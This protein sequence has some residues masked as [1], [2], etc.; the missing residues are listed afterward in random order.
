MLM[1]IQMMLTVFIISITF[2]AETEFQRGIILFG[3]AADRT[4]MFGDPGGGMCLLFEIM[5][6]FHLLRRH[7]DMVSAGQEE[8]NKIEEG[9][10]DNKPGYHS[11]GEAF[12]HQHGSVNDPKPFHLDRDDKHKQNLHFRKGCRIC[13]EYGHIDV[14]GTEGAKIYMDSVAQGIDSLRSQR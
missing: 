8:Y 13:Q 2:G 12:K 5:S 11:S 4:F 3:P 6:P 1:G 14:V 10:T 7:V 9:R